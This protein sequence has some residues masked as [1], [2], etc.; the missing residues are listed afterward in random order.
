[1]ISP[2]SSGSIMPPSRLSN[3]S[4]DTSVP[5]I[6]CLD[7]TTT[8]NNDLCEYTLVRAD[9][10]DLLNESSSPYKP[11]PQPIDLKG[12]TL[13][14]LKTFRTDINRVGH[15]DRLICGDMTV[16]SPPDD[17]K[18]EAIVAHIHALAQG[19]E[20]KALDLMQY[21]SFRPKIDLISQVTEAFQKKVGQNP[22]F[23]RETGFTESTILLEECGTGLQCSVS[24]VINHAVNADMDMTDVSY[25]YKATSVYD[26]SSTSPGIT[27]RIELYHND[28]V[29]VEANTIP[30]KV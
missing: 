11:S 13:S 24:G 29:N 19:D 12:R 26:F 9:F 1:M 18:F 21:W 25:E 2:S 22:I 10:L 5:N 16:S 27:Y 4:P 30:L 17:D 6:E 20:S 8:I 15:P 23:N 14:F 28:W 3:Y 7:V